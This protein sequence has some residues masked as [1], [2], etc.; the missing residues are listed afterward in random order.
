MKITPIYAAILAIVFIMLSLRTI[1]LRRKFKVAV[2]HDKNTELLRAIR[3]HANFAEYVPMGLLLLYMLE[4]ISSLYLLIH[5][6]CMSLLI[7]RVIHAYSV[8]QLSEN[9]QLRII[10]MTMTFAALGIAAI[11]ILIASTLNSLS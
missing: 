7:G 4:S 6:L 11:G 8:S 2:G 3:A 10:G 1:K 9:F 5:T